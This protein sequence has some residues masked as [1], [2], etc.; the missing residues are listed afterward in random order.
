MM[1]QEGK[2]I[3]LQALDARRA[4]KPK[5]IDNSSLYAGSSMYY[6]CKVCGHISDVLPESYFGRPRQLCGEC[7]ALKDCGWLE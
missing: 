1:T 2:E 4:D 7:Q 6:Y 3:A 5:Q